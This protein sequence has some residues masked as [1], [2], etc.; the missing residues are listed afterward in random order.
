MKMKN[1]FL[2]II[3]QANQNWEFEILLWKKFPVWITREN[4]YK[5]STARYIS[6]QVI[7]QE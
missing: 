7:N 3:I 5:A 4:I 1:T 6:S 2:L